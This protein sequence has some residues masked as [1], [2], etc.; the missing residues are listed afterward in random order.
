M[1]QISAVGHDQ[2]RFANKWGE[3]CEGGAG[4]E[5]KSDLPLPKVIC[6]FHDAIES[7][8]DT[9][10]CGT[11]VFGRKAECHDQG[12]PKSVGLFYSIFQRMVVPGPLGCL[13]P[14]QDVK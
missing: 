2:S 11:R 8:C 13:H 3:G 4:H 7:E 5:V 14:V 1:V 9:S 6:N 12:E 10:G